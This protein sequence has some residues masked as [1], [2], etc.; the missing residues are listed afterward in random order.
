MGYCRRRRW[1]AS[2]DLGPLVHTIYSVRTTGHFQKNETGACIFGGSSRISC[3]MWDRELLRFNGTVSLISFTVIRQ[4]QFKC[5]AGQFYLEFPCGRGSL[6]EIVGGNL[7]FML[8]SK[9]SHIYTHLR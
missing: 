3:I 2:P 4:G 7:V 6:G 1:P 8:N 5:T 9:Y